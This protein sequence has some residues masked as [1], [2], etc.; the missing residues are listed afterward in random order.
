M[1]TSV[2]ELPGLDC[3]VCGFR[4]CAELAVRLESDPQMIKRCIHL[5]KSRVAAPEK[6]AAAAA[7]SSSACAPSSCATCGVAMPVVGESAQ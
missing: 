5:S 3:G 4:T 2:T 6:P 1:A 7:C